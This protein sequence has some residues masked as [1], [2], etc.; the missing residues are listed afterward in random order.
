MLSLLRTSL[1]AT[2]LLALCLPAEVKAQAW[3]EGPSMTVARS[4]AAVAVLDGPNGPEF[5]VI[6]G[7]TTTGQPLDVVEKFDPQTGQWS[8]VESLRND[9]YAASAVLFQDRILL[10]G[11]SENDGAT[12]DVEVYV[13][14]EDDWESFDDLES[15]RTGL[16]AVVLDGHVYAFGGASEEG[17]FLTSCETYDPDVEVWNVYPEWVLNPGRASFGAATV[18]EAVY[19]AGGFS[20][21]GPIDTVERYDLENG[22]TDLAPLSSS[23]GRLALVHTGGTLGGDLFALGGEDA[24]GVLDTV[25][26]YDI[27]QNTWTPVASLATPRAGAA[28]AYI[29]GAIYVV[30]GED[31]DRRALRTMEVFGIMTSTED[32]STPTSFALDAVYPNPFADRTTL[33]FSLAE[34][35][36]V[37]LTVYDVQGRRVATLADRTMAAGA[38]R[39]TWDGRSADGRSLPA[40]VYVVRIVSDAGAATA[41]LTLLR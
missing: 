12:D 39:V 24:D 40:G 27:E 4:D 32:P 1:L 26:R 22:S 18:G 5:Y 28:A 19:T 23:R 34:P 15:D 38:H 30:G 6:G 11:G 7:R 36:L 17:T 31:A 14:S 13:P 37:T 25:E 16:G 9:R 35:G 20:Q 3:S 10:M 8:S 21:F 41:K 2:L 33:S 29:D